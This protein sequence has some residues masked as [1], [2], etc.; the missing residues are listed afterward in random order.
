[1]GITRQ[2]IV[3]AQ[4]STKRPTFAFTGESGYTLGSQRKIAHSGSHGKTGA[5]P[6]SASCVALCRQRNCSECRICTPDSAVLLYTYISRFTV[7]PHHQ[8]MRKIRQS[9]RIN[10]IHQPFLIPIFNFSH[11]CPCLLS[12]AKSSTHSALLKESHT[13][14][15]R[16]KQGAFRMGRYHY[17]RTVP[18]VHKHPRAGY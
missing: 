5:F 9:C 3:L 11:K 10:F 15:H 18:H 7:N 2:K 6:P 1:M 13:A 8:Q 12:W 16:A 14:A 4:S 17:P